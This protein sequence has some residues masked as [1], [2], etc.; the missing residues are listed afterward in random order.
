MNREGEFEIRE[1]AFLERWYRKDYSVIGGTIEE[2]IKMKVR[3]GGKRSGFSGEMRGEY[4][5]A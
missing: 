4:N 1:G 2:G 5:T 3:G